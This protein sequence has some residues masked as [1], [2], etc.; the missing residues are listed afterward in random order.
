MLRFCVASVRPRGGCLLQPFISVQKLSVKA[1]DVL[2]R[3]PSK[4]NSISSRSVDGGGGHGGADTSASSSLFRQESKRP[5]LTTTILLRNIGSSVTESA[6]KDAVKDCKYRRLDLEPGC[7]IHVV[8][9]ADASFAADK[10]KE[11]LGI[12][13]K[14]SKAVMPAL[15]LQNI[16]PDMSAD[17]LFKAF[18]KH[19]PQVVHFIGGEGLQTS[20]PSAGDALKAA[21]L[22]KEANV[23]GFNM[24]TNIGQLPN[25]SF[26]LQV[27]LIY[28]RFAIYRDHFHFLISFTQF[29]IP[30]H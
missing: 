24:S 11:R 16:A 5:S 22:I 10:I 8:S 23:Q 7:A 13:T 1:N 18:H 28:Y 4:K 20:L 2:D 14:V 9:A 12:E 15:L 17:L 3:S 21:K 19:K 30:L 25:G 29:Y 26:S 27:A 6:L